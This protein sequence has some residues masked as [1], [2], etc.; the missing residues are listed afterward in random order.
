M[1]NI[2]LVGFMGT[3]KTTIGKR[4][5]EQTQMPLVD[6]DALIEKRAKKS[7]SQIFADEGEAHFRTLERALA[8]ELTTQNNLIISTGGGIVLNPNNIS[9]FET[10]GLTVCLM[11]SPE[12][13]LERIKH[14]TSRPL[15]A[16]DKEN[17]IIHL[18]ESRQTLYE[19][20]KH[21]IDTNG[22]DPEAI[23]SKILELY[24]PNNS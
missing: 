19:A 18:L 10:S 8:K 11:A 21:K 14:D 23:T 24:Q 3:G 16:G 22:L 4:L 1:K 12:T 6:M 7:I 13:I 17:Q 5:A 20:V 15:L 9:D 2:I